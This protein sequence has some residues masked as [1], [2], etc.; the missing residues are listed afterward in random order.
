MEIED[1]QEYII[2]NSVTRCLE[3][4]N[5]LNLFSLAFPT[6]GGG[7]ARFPHSRIAK[8]MADVIS[9]FLLKTNKNFKIDLI[10]FEKA[11]NRYIEY[12]CCL[13]KMFY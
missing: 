13:I 5:S 6:I 12:Y 2:K 1:I 10:I 9:L 8:A 7:T 4:M 11:N 3:I